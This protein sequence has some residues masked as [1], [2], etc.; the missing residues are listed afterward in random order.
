MANTQGPQGNYDPAGST[1]MFRAFVDEAPQGRRQEASSGP[2]V[3]LIV[4]VVAVVV[5]L[6]A[7]AWLAFK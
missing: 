6:A 2:R 5:I 4:G 3:G 1:Q 7:V